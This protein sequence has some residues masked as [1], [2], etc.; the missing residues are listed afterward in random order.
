MN[1]LINC[2]LFSDDAFSIT[3]YIVSDDKKWFVIDGM[4]RICKVPS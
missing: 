1:E 3:D 4:E 2:G